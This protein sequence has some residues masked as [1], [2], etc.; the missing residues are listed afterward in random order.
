MYSP[1]YCVLH[2]FSTPV[3]MSDWFDLKGKWV[4]WER[5]INISLPDYFTENKLLATLMWHLLIRTSPY[6]RMSD[7]PGQIFEH[8]KDILANFSNARTF[9][10][11]LAHFGKEEI[12]LFYQI[13]TWTDF[14]NS[15]QQSYQNSYSPEIFRIRTWNQFVISSKWLKYSWSIYC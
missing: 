3:F 10:Q 14:V 8:L 7:L 13:S 12:I 1:T 5:I 6:T 15:I 9:S 4:Q 2:W 11:F